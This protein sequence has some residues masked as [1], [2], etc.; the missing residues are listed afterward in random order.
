M[1]IEEIRKYTNDEELIVTAQEC[2]R[3]IGET[4]SWEGKYKLAVLLEGLNRNLDE[5]IFMLYKDAAENGVNNA[6]ALLGLARLYKSG[7]GCKRDISKAFSFCF[8]AAE[9]GN[10]DAEFYLAK[11]FRD[12]SQELA[13]YWAEHAAN[14]NNLQAVM[15]AGDLLDHFAA[16]HRNGQKYYDAATQYYKKGADLGISGAKGKTT[17]IGKLL[18]VL[19]IA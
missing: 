8:A 11:I 15:L 19:R 13:L 5:D 14:Q 6:S 1:T 2:L 10:T 18:R 7:K 12:N 17:V 3:Q 9:M 16:R 4:G